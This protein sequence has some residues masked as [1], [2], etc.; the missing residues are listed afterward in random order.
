MAA[1][2]WDIIAHTSSIQG[3][4]ITL[5]GEMTLV[6]LVGACSMQRL[7]IGAG[8]EVEAGSCKW[9]KWLLMKQNFSKGFQGPVRAVAS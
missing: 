5:P 6:R 2:P 3:L 9:P 1:L 4:W 8:S 7:G